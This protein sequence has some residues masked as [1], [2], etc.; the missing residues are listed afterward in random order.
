MNVFQ[1]KAGERKIGMKRNCKII[2]LFVIAAGVL[3]LLACFLPP[4]VMVC[5][6]AA[7]LIAVGIL[8]LSL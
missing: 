7:L 1:I 4:I 2:G 6:E 3:L 5:V 8:Y